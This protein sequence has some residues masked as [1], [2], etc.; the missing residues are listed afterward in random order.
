TTR[1]V[2]LPAAVKE[3]LE[4]RAAYARA[5]GCSAHAESRCWAARVRRHLSLSPADSLR[6]VAT[7]SPPSGPEGAHHWHELPVAAARMEREQEAAPCG[8]RSA[9]S[10]TPRGACAHSCQAADPIRSHE[11]ARLPA[12]R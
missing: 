12:P 3:E 11:P 6:Q 5:L 7:A 8:L 2:L 4:L 1:R 10:R 9:D